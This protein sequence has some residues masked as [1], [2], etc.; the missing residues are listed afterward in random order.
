MDFWQER[1]PGLLVQVDDGE[2]EDF[3]RW[4]DLGGHLRGKAL[5][6]TKG[7]VLVARDRRMLEEWDESGYE[8]DRFGEGPF[9]LMYRP[10]GKLNQR[11]GHMRMRPEEDPYERESVDAFEPYTIFVAARNLSLV[12]AVTPP[13]EAGGFSEDVIGALIGLSGH[14]READELIERWRQAADRWRQEAQ[15]AAEAGRLAVSALFES[16]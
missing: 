2:S 11:R 4:S 9:T 3:V 8:L 12:T 13:I 1:W 16:L 6:P 7:E 10:L 5:H 14:S 15:R